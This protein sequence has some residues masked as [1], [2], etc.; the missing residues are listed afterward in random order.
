MLE[1]ALEQSTGDEPEEQE[2]VESLVGMEVCGVSGSARR[3][4]ETKLEMVRGTGGTLW[5]WQK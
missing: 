2:G 4:P 3:D 1:G 5:T